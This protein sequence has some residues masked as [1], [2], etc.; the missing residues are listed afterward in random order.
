MSDKNQF[1]VEYCVSPLINSNYSSQIEQFYIHS[2]CTAA[3]IDHLPLILRLDPWGY[4]GAQST[5]LEIP[6]NKICSVFFFISWRDVQP[7]SIIVSTQQ[8]ILIIYNGRTNVWSGKYN[9]MERSFKSQVNIHINKSSIH[10]H[11]FY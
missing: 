1:M 7:K 6:F 9:R 8:F 3:K 2:F 11:M 5:W 10:S 4:F